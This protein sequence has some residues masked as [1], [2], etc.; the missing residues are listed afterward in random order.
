MARETREVWAERDR[1][2][3]AQR[4]DG[5]AVRRTRGRQS[6]DAD[7]LEVEARPRRS[8][9]TR[10]ARRAADEQPTVAFVEVLRAAAPAA[11]PGRAFE[12]VRAGR[13]PR[14]RRRRGSTARRCAR[15]STCSRGG[16]DPGGRPDLPLHRARRYAPI[17]RWARARRARAARAGSAPGRAL[18]LRQSPCEPAARCSGSI[19]TG[20]ASSTSACTRRSS[21]CRGRRTGSRCAS[22]EPRS[23]SSSRAWRVRRDAGAHRGGR[24]NKSVDY[25]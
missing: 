25:T 20:T 14:R 1:A 12:I 7:V 18:R 23:C 21:A 5:G 13:L 8:R 17:V 19:G 16:D 15:C 4:P 9:R 2:L 3:A 11:A 24:A 6:A 10:R 22:T